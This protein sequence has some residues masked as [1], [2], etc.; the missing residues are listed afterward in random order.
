ME[1]LSSSFWRAVSIGETQELGRSRRA[2]R[3]Q[4]RT[5]TH[6]G[7]MML[8]IVIAVPGRVSFGRS[9]GHPAV[10]TGNGQ[11]QTA[12]IDESTRHD[13][14]RPGAT[15]GRERLRS[16]R[17]R[18]RSVDSQGR[19]ERVDGILLGARSGEQLGRWA[20]AGVRRGTEWCAGRG[21]GGN[22]VMSKRNGVAETWHFAK[23][24]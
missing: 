11:Q 23:E 6:R 24:G 16:G 19:R 3:R 10:L 7:I 15:G 13:D 1:R 18:G 22:G 9:A 20:E 8:A 14:G 2:R 12:A 21:C 17:E 5:E 4:K